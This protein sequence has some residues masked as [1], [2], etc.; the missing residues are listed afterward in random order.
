MPRVPSARLL[1][2][3]KHG[4]NATV[5]GSF[6]NRPSTIYV[7]GIRGDDGSPA[8]DYVMWEIADN[9]GE[10]IVAPVNSDSRDPRANYGVAYHDRLGPVDEGTMLYRIAM[11]LR[12]DPIDW[13]V[14]MLGFIDAILLGTE[15]EP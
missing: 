13:D 5:Y 7:S 10:Y 1:T 14:R 8:A 15:N 6:P 11:V 9:G 4:Y 2:A 12:G 3:L